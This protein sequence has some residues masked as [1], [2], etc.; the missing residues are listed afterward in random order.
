[1]W[2]LGAENTLMILLVIIFL[3]EYCTLFYKIKTS[4]IFYGL[5]YGE[6]GC[7]LNS[8]S[9]FFLEHYKHDAWDVKLKKQFQVN[10]EVREI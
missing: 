10:Q 2:K 7:I 1:M 4:A 3:H 9:Y 6:G 5:S 8:I